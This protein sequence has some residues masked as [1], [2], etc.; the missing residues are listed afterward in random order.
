MSTKKKEGS[1]FRIKRLDAAR[2]EHLFADDFRLYLC[3]H[4]GG[5]KTTTWIN[6][7]LSKELNFKQNFENIIIFSPTFKGDPKFYQVKDAGVIFPEDVHTELTMEELNKIAKKQEQWIEMG[8]EPPRILIVFDDCI[9]EKMFKTTIFQNYIFRS[10]HWHMS[11][12]I[13]SQYWASLPK[14]IRSNMNYIM[15]F[16]MNNNE[17][18]DIYETIAHNNIKWP[19]FEMLY[20]YALKP[21]EYCPKPFLFWMGGMGNKYAKCFDEVLTIVRP[22][23]EKKI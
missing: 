2:P 12:L 13:N 18:Y 17:L 14:K 5:G 3:G 4:A 22:T 21:D 11:I 7:L 23:E 10:R 20:N 1:L 15:V 19:E 16:Q 6:M 9:S 8:A